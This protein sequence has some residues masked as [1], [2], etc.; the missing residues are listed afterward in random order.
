M[1]I[2]KKNKALS[3]L[4]KHV[5]N[6][7]TWTSIEQRLSIQEALQSL[8]THTPS[9]AIWNA[10]NSNLESKNRLRWKRYLAVAA[11]ILFLISSQFTLDN[12]SLKKTTFQYSKEEVNLKLLEADWSTTTAAADQIHS[13][14]TAQKIAC[15]SL[16]FKELEQEL[17]TLDHAKAELETAMQLVG[18]S[19]DLIAQMTSIEL[20]RSTLLKEMMNEV[21]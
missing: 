12:L 1:S 2:E 19:T 13:F 9:N 6:D 7:E 11:T 3:K 18:K 14:C 16:I 8:P 4:P 10:I 21:L 15:S 5:P 20:E 17:T